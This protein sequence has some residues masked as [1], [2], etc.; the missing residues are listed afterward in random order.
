MWGSDGSCDLDRLEAALERGILL[1]V[2]AVLVERGRADGLQLAAGEQRL[3]D[4]GRVDR[5]LGGTRT[6]QGVDLVDEGDDVAAGADLL[7]DLL[8]ALL[9]VTAVAGA[10]D[11]RAE[12]ERVELLVLQRLGHVAADDRLGEALD[13]GGLADAG[14]ADQHRVVLGAA[15]EDLH[16]PLDLLLAP[17]HRVELVVARGLREVAAE[18]VED[19]R[20]RPAAA[21]WS[22]PPTC[23]LLLALVAAEQLDDLLAHAVEVGAE[24]DEHLGGD[25]LALA[26]EAEQ[27][28]LG[29]D[30]V[31][32]ELQRLAQRE[33]EHLL[34]ARRERDVAGRLLLTLADDVLDLLAHGVERDAERLERLG[35]DTL[36][37]MDQP[38]Q[39]VLGADVVVVEHLGLFLGQ[40]DDATGSVGES[41]EHVL[42][43]KRHGR[44]GAVTKRVTSGGA[45]YCPCSPWALTGVRMR[46]PPGVSRGFRA[47]SASSRAA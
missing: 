21:A 14:L 8:Q 33:L 37:L 30:V 19:L 46:S 2:L 43:L 4:A 34:G 17:D 29:A 15:G 36:T 22:L 28:V 12:V 47:R 31:V 35:G 39:D 13:D 41:L 11:E 1:E 44:V 26:D 3:Q 9:E 20:C 40:D 6:D 42:L 25:A 32:A 10:G 16:D 27:D 18:L 38:E 45:R 7:G 5:A 23:D 24:L